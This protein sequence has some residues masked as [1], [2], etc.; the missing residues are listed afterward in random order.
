[1]A[2]NITTSTGI[3]AAKA[4]ASR[5]FPNERHPRRGTNAE[6]S[7]SRNPRRIRGTIC[8]LRPDSEGGAAR[9]QGHQAERGHAD[10]LAGARRSVAGRRQFPP[11]IGSED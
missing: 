6:A 1:M 2:M 4:Y 11:K 3:R 9:N 8:L 10:R 7:A 5:A